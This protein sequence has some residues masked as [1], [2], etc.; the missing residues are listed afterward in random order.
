MKHFIV[1]LTYSVPFEQLAGLVPEHRGFLQAGYDR[2]WLLM[3]GPQ[4]PK[5]GGIV[6]ARAPSL[7]ALQAYFGGDPFARHGAA[8]YRYIEFEP[9]RRQAAMEDWAAGE[10]PSTHAT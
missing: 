2:G 4:S 5:T 10:P 7:E 1:E 9:V 3:S 8:A 6:V